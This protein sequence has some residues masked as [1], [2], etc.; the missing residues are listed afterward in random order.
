MAKPTSRTTLKEYCLRKLGDGAIKVNVTDA[1]AEDRINRIGQE[2][3]CLYTRLEADTDVDRIINN[4]IIKKR[5]WIAGVVH[6][7][8]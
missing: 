2:S 5:V 3:E 8:K 4:I 7:R 1:Q 6:T